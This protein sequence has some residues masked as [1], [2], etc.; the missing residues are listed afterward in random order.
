MMYFNKIMPRLFVDQAFAQVGKVTSKGSETVA[1][2]QGAVYELL[3]TIWDKIDNWIAALV[4]VGFSIYLANS[5][6]KLTINKIAEHLDEEHQD[7]LI[8]AGRA[9]YITVLGLGVTIGLKVGGIDITAIVAAVGFGI[10]FAMRDLV[11]N[12]IAGI[13][14]MITRNYTIGDWIQVGSTFGQIVEIQ[15]R[16]TILKPLDGTKV[17]V[18]NAELFSNQVT[19]FTSNPFRRIDLPVGVHYSTD[20]RKVAQIALEVMKNDSDIIKEPEPQVVFDAFADSS[21]NL[22][23][24]FWID[25]KN[26]WIKIRSELLVH[27]KEAFD[28]E[29]INIPFPIRTLVFE[30]ESDKH[31]AENIAKLDERQMEKKEKKEARAKYLALEAESKADKA[32]SKEDESVEMSFPKI[33]PAKVN[34]TIKTA[35]IEISESE[36]GISI[37]S[38]KN[39]FPDD[40]GSIFLKNL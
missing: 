17:I 32:Q 6:R 19:S 5:F 33:S 31:R 9:T 8:L 27:L 39:P 10:G 36:K 35:P 24:R 29:E 1:Q 15:G 22:I 38:L 21:I 16:A 37:S 30:N 2:S 18:P 13:I 4:V 7:M 20:L 12:F 11:M 23:L 28:R 3:S 25:S 34:P 14:L 40:E 26:R